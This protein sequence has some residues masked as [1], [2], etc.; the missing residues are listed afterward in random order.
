MKRDPAAEG[1]ADPGRPPG[2]LDRAAPGRLDEAAAGR[3]ETAASGRLDDAA[4][5][6][7]DPAAWALVHDRREA[8]HFAF[9]RGVELAHEVCAERVRPGE[10]WIEAGCGPGHLAA[11]LARLGARVVGFDLD[12][13]MARYGRRR[14][15]QPFAVAE[16]SLPPVADGCCAGIVA[17]SL[18]GCLPLPEAFF[19]AAE[20]A[21]A[22]GGTLCFSAMNR[23]SLLLAAGKALAWRGRR[24][25]PHY[26][27]HD[28]AALT[29]ALVRAGLAPERQLF[30][31]HFL[32]TGR[33]TMPSPA[34]AQRL[35]RTAPPGQ[36]SVWARQVLL[37][38]RRGDPA[39]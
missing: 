37:V 10:L 5:G 23:R 24:G 2:R 36:R 38:A 13:R 32:G 31:G 27:S 8:R 22:P 34:A 25:S 14:W 16:A 4:P 39:S 17:V 19:A 35:E 7:L 3:C 29:A 30:Y 33:G 11:A 1:L 18:L 28:P 21:L 15:R 12:L 9:W 26:A 6:R 20:R